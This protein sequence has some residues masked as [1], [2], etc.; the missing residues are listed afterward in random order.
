MTPGIG[1]SGRRA[2]IIG[3]RFRMMATSGL[4]LQRQLAQGLSLCSPATWTM[5]AIVGSV[6]FFYW[7]SFAWL[8]EE[9]SSNNGIFSHGYLVAGICIF[10]IFRA[11]LSL[12]AYSLAPSW[13]A[14]PVL[15]VLSLVW[16]LGNAA[17]EATVQTMV[18]R[19][20]TMSSRISRNVWKR[21]RWISRIPSS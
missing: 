21:C 6:L 12:S 18:S 19:N 3:H 16:L 1:D 15:L 2:T 4:T 14:I 13:V 7:P 11:T 20:A 5:L 9:W 10:L 17:D 8:G